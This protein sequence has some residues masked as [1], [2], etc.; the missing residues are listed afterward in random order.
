[1]ENQTILDKITAIGV[2]YAQGYSIAMPRPLTFH[3]KLLAEVGES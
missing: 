1:V 3:N 2:D